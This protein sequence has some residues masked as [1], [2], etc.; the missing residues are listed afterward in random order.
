LACS[1]VTKAANSAGV[2]EI[3]HGPVTLVERGY[4]IL[5]F[6]PA[7]A[8]GPGVLAA[9]LPQRTRRCSQPERTTP[10]PERTTPRPAACPAPAA[11]HPETD[12]VCLIQAFYGMAD[13]LAARRGTDVERPRHLQ[14]VTQAQ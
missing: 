3:V 10:Q 14:K 8:A 4:P 9:T 1:A 2:P 6:M 13:Q 12:A 11:D 7:D 5:T